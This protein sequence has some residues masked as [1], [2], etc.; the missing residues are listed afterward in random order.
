MK[1]RSWACVH[2]WPSPSS[3]V[4]TGAAP[5]T[6][7]SGTVSSVMFA[8]GPGGPRP[9]IAPRSG[10]ARPRLRSFQAR[11]ETSA[12]NHQEVARRF[13]EDV[14]AAGRADHDVLDARPVAALEVDS[15]LD[16]EG[17]PDI[18]RLAVAGHDVGI[19]VD[20]EPDPM[21]RTVQESRPV[22]GHGDEIA[23]CAVDGLP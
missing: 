8:S 13:V 19:L 6:S 5:S 4:S 7:A 16:R 11:S 18:E 10:A 3:S 21:A 12:G 1:R 15:R 22:A 2:W 14:H 23:R 9:M 20:L 17:H